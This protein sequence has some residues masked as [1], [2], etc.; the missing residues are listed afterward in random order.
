MFVA[1]GVELS[2]LGL[3]E[4]E[5]EEYETGEVKLYIDPPLSEVDIDRLEYELYTQGVTL[6]A[7]IRQGGGVV[8]IMFQKRLA[9]LVIIAMVAGGIFSVI[10]G[11][12]GWQLSKAPLGIPWWVWLIGAG[13]VAYLLFQ[14]PI[15]QAGRL[16]V[17]AGKMYLFKKAGA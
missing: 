10:A 14:E 17:E 12:L 5:F 15:H 1:E 3:Y 4:N 8:S 13:A 11:F 6:I 9:P 2:T 7:P 16:G